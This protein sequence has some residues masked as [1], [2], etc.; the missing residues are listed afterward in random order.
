MTLGPV[1]GC[2][3]YF[4]DV[5]G[6]SGIGVK[7]GVK[8]ISAGLVLPKELGEDLG[9]SGNQVAGNTITDLLP[10]SGSGAA[11][12]C[13]PTSLN[14]GKTSFLFLALLQTKSLPI[15]ICIPPIANTGCQHMT[16]PSP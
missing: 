8:L 6:V 13:V 11:C 7:G 14:L 4:G 1:H 12:T 5:E 3:V 10:S 9:A 15:L 16:R 2:K